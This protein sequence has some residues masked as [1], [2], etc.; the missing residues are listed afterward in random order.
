MFHAKLN[1]LEFSHYQIEFYGNLD[2]LNFFLVLLI[3][4]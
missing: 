4:D 2:V 3:T 1:Q